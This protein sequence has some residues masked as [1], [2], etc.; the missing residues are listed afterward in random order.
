MSVVF[1]CCVMRRLV[2]MV[3]LDGGLFEMA[4]VA[5]LVCVTND[6]CLLYFKFEFIFVALAMFFLRRVQLRCFSEEKSN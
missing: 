1:V 4:R 6:F 2:G 5:R 3:E